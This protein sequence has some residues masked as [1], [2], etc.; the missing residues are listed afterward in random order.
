LG[1]PIADDRAELLHAYSMVLEILYGSLM[2]LC[3]ASATESS[4]IFALA[5]LGILLG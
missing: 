2:R 5:R 3:R 1:G 4:K